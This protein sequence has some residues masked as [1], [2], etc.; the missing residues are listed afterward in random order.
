MYNVRNIY[1]YPRAGTSM[2]YDNDENQY[3]TY[4]VNPH[5]Y[6]INMPVQNPYLLNRFPVRH[7]PYYREDGHH[8]PIELKDYGPQPFVVDI[9]DAAKI[10]NNFRLALW[11]GDHLQLTLMSI[12]VGEDIGLEVHPDLD[13]FIRI[14]E[15]QGIVKMGDSR[16]NLDFQRRVYDDYA[17]IIP[18]GKWHNLINTGYKPLKLYSIYAPPQ[19]PRGTVH[20]TRT[21]AHAAERAQMPQE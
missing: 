21:A 17:F 16:N 7:N 4:I 9:E 10:N 20:E 3:D 8:N 12:D 18:A 15:G 1:S 2:Y 11:T 14:E 5:H 19:H 13:Q 6:C